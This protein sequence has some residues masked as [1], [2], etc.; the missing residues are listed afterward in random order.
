[1]L[2][3]LAIAATI[4]SA[5]S[6]GALA[7]RDGVLVFS[8]KDAAGYHLTI[9]DRTGTRA[10]PVPPSK[11]PFD[12]SLGTDARG[13]TLAVYSRC[14]IG[15]RGWPSVAVVPGSC[16]LYA[17]DLNTNRERAITEVNRRG[18]SEAAPSLDHGVLV[19]GRNFALRA[20]PQLPMLS[21]RTRV[22]MHR[23][24]TRR[25]R[26]LMTLPGANEPGYTYSRDVDLRSSAISGPRVALG[27]FEP[28]EYGT[29]MYLNDRGVR[30]ERLAHGGFGEDNERRHGSP[31]FAGRYLYWS[32]SNTS[33]FTHPPNGWV[34]RRDLR[35]G[36]TVTA[37]APGYV[38]AVAADP[39]R[40]GAPLTVSSF[41]EKD[42]DT[43]TATGTDA[44]QTLDA[45]VWGRVPRS[46][47]LR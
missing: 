43:G 19:F 14:R 3:A 42:P 1:M 32:Y 21:Y 2:H 23:L 34:L 37:E 8:T 36:R 33:T 38:E 24:G 26:T 47:F 11:L 35:S 4:I 25:E 10:L 15:E 6:G 45:P 16:D 9:H 46:I 17:F 31:A 13:R 29:A 44:V 18:V 5:Q 20:K 40:P 30:F 41:A 39:L 28:A 22:L 12:V 27:V 7:A